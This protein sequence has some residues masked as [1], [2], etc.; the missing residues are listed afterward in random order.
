MQVWRPGVDAIAED[1]EL[2]YDPTAYDCLH[3]FSHSDTPPPLVTVC[4]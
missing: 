4:T 3:K 1:E 2:S